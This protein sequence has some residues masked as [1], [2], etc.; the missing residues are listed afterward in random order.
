MQ[1]RGSLASLKST[2]PELVAA[3]SLLVPVA[4][5]WVCA[6][7]EITMLH[8]CRRLNRPAARFPAALAKAC[9]ERP[10]TIKL[11]CAAADSGA[12]HG[13]CTVPAAA[14]SRLASLLTIAIR[15]K[16]KILHLKGSLKPDDW[17]SLQG[18]TQRQATESIACVS[19]AWSPCLV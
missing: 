15:R 12:V 11:R 9:N 14:I 8:C 4:Y 17:N 5:R 16:A 19:A 3:A 1:Y 10:R 2:G 6:G 7:P 18:K 13:T